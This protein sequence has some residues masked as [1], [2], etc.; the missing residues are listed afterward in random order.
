MQNM[1]AM[2]LVGRELEWSEITAQWERALAGQP[3]IVVLAGEAGLGKSRLQAEFARSAGQQGACVLSGYATRDSEMPGYF[4]FLVALGAHLRDLG[5]AATHA[6]VAHLDALA[7]IFPELQRDEPARLNAAPQ[8]PEQAKWR[9]HDAITQWLCALSVDQ[10]VLLVLDDMQW[11]EPATVELLTFVLRNAR[12]ARLMILAACRSDQSDSNAS[13]ENAVREWRRLRHLKWIDIAPLSPAAVGELASIHLSG[14][15]SSAL[16]SAL[17]QHSEGNPYFAEEL[18]QAWRRSGALSMGQNQYE[19]DSARIGALPA[20]IAD[21]IEERLD[22][23][24][25]RAR[26]ILEA[27]AVVGNTF[28]S[29]LLSRALAQPVDQLERE[30]EPATAVHLIHAVHNSDGDYAFHHGKVRDVLY[31]GLSPSRR[32]MLHRALGDCLEQ[33]ADGRTNAHLMAALATH[34]S[35]GGEVERARAYFLKT[36]AACADTY[37]FAEAAQHYRSAVDGMSGTHDEYGSVLL[38]LGE[39]QLLSGHAQDARATFETARGWFHSAGDMQN[40]AR[41]AHQLGVAAWRLEDLPAARAAF[42]AALSG[43]RLHPSPGTVS[44]L[45]DLASLLSVSLHQQDAGLAYAHDALAMAERL[46]DAHALAAVYRTLGNL[47]ARANRLD[48]GVVFLENALVLAETNRAIFEAAE[49]CANLSLTLAWATQ[50]RRAE[51]Y[52]LRWEK[53]ALATRDLYQLRHTYS[54]HAMGHIVR[55]DWA[56]A[57]ACLRQSQEI[58]EQLES[59]EPAAT[60]HVIRGMLAFYRGQFAQAEAHLAAASETFRQYGPGAL[61]WYLGMQGV[62]QAR[63]GKREDALACYAEVEA[64]VNEMPRGIIPTAE[65]SVHLALIA[66]ALDL[67]ERMGPLLEQ[68]LPFRGQ[69]HD[70]L[71]DRVLAELAIRRKDLAFARQSLN[72]AEAIAR[73]Q[74]SLAEL[75]LI[76]RL[77]PELTTTH[78]PT[79]LPYGLSAREVEV[80]RLVT[81]GRSNRAIAKVLSLSEKTVANHLTSVFGKLGVDNRAAATAMA[82]R[83][84]LD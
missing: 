60:L 44:L 57:D 79:Q 51:D 58:V 11:A 66:L 76:E 3:G 10:P 52:Q 18:L 82:V 41:A 14:P 9:L 2:Q 28:S 46:E 77:R 72:Q 48:E 71:V 67:R 78:I 39:M 1:Q 43:L 22:L 4:P 47:L 70:A 35:K 50:F 62:C 55:G 53:H 33:Q 49:C 83:L 68:L 15:P 65:P 42:E 24:A 27:A 31:S 59:D 56:Q 37:A 80:L 73:K 84:E 75:A 16:I 29:L 5:P 8:S 81:Q 45:V 19:L 63:Q 64:M 17:Y 13:W 38:R 40:S 26:A 12:A 36:A 7:T 6:P 69:Y 34:F 61:V 20:S 74:G 32:R 54:L 25:P 21:A 30:L 23:L